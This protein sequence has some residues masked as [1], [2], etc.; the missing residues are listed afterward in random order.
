MRKPAWVALA[1]VSL[2]VVPI[3]LIAQCSSAN[4]GV[5]ATG[6]DTATLQAQLDAVTPG[7]TLRLSRKT[8]RHSGVIQVRTPGVKIEGHGAVIEATN[9]ASSSVQIVADGVS[10]SNVSLKAPIQGKRWTGIDQNKLVIAADG[11]LVSDVLISGSAAAGVFVS[12]ASRFRLDGVTV[13]RSR[14]DGVHITNGSS[15]GEVDNVSTEWT[16]DDG[17][18]VV[19]YGNEPICRNIVVDHPTVDGT[20]WGRGVSVVGGQNISYKDVAIT[21]SNAAGI[22]VASEGHPYY[23]HSTSNVQVT[24]GTVTGANTN[25]SIAQGAVLVY[26][27]HAGRDVSNIL[28]SDVALQATSA[29]ARVNIGV[30]ADQGRLSNILIAGIALRDTDLPPTYISPQ[31][32]QDSYTL[33]EWTRDG[34][35]IDDP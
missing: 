33:S 4:S 25:G 15:N 35:P 21:Q 28:I 5:A 9:D 14:A 34:K 31:V 10:L 23:T 22:Y 29:T 8:Y 18:A 32:A 27:Q 6:D 12:G 3:L 16:G 17:I 13:Q 7:G 1:L 20:T 30:V 19:S 2:S 11:V 26:A 24:G